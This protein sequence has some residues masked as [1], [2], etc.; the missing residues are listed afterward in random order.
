MSTP[1]NSSQRCDFQFLSS[2]TLTTED[3]QPNFN[4]ASK[5]EFSHYIEKEIL[6]CNWNCED[7]SPEMRTYL[8]IMGDPPLGR[9]IRTIECV[10]VDPVDRNS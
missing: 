9:G 10:I 3:Q 6:E 8:F 5:T 4:S 7:D 1:I 2:R